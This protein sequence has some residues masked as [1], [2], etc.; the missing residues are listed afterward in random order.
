MN[1]NVEK[2]KYTFLTFEKTPNERKEK[3]AIL[4]NSSSPGCL[5]QLEIQRN[6]T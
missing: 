3:K 5:K 6:T 2:E 4:P 1:N